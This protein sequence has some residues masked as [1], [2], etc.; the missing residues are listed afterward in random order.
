MQ[1]F[2]ACFTGLSQYLVFIFIY[3]YFKAYI[4]IYIYL[5]TGVSETFL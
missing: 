2:F 4:Y 5:I 3:I 1:K